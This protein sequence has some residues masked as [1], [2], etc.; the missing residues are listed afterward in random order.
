VG[1]SEG[2]VV[3][4]LLNRQTEAVIQGIQRSRPLDSIGRALTLGFAR[5][6]RP[7]KLKDLVSGTW[8]GHPLHPLL[9]DVPI[10]S[11]TSAFVL[12][13]L[14]GEAAQGAADMLIGLGVVSAVP[15]AV[16]G[17]SEL[18]DV[19]E[20]G[21][22]SVG[23]AH[24]IG[25]VTAVA[26]FGMSYALRRR[27]KRGP[28]TA[29]SLAGA[30][31]ATASAYLGGHLVFRQVVGPSRALDGP[32]PDWTPVLDAGDLAEGKPKRVTVGGGQIMLYKEGGRTYALINR[33]SHRGGP[34]HKGTVGHGRATCPWHL[35]VFSLEDGSVIQGPATAPQPTY[36]VREREGK[37]EIRRL[38]L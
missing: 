6:V 17:L 34:L 26:L 37:V 33:C 38:P 12:D 35:S 2:G 25:N 23:S 31:V 4:T 13:L 3:V 18:A 1:R 30:A 29:L 11:W 14:G 28:G 19:T 15:T 9:T 22:R 32:L 21:E 36:E 8:L 16:T 5:V 24:A 7:G 10:G 20:K 27:G